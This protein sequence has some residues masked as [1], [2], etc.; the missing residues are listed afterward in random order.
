MV[1]ISIRDTGVGIAPERFG[2]LFEQFNIDGDTSASKYGSTGLGLALS[3]KISRL[4]GGDLACESKLNVGSCF[5][6]MIPADIKGAIQGTTDDDRVVADAIH[7][8]E[9]FHQQLRPLVARAREEDVEA[10]KTLPS[11]RA[12]ANA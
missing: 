3:Q 6:I 2:S 5:T 10:A 12:A 8:A 4:L 1:A 11:M 7:E 9:A